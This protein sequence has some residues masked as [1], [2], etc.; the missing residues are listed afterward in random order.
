ME[1]KRRRIFRRGAGRYIGFLAALFVMFVYLVSGLINLQLKQ[2]DYYLEK[3]EDTR[4]KTI[5]LRGKR[6][7]IVSADSVILAEDEMIYKIGRAS[8]R[9]RV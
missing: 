6:G 9:E 8:C 3:A 1:K 5:A 4:T 7:N 2:E